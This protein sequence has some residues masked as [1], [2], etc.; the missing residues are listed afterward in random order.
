MKFTIHETF[1]LCPEVR[2]R[3]VNELR[4]LLLCPRLHTVSIRIECFPLKNE[5]EL[6]DILRAVAEVYAR[7]WGKIG[8]RFKLTGGRIGAT[9]EGSRFHLGFRVLYMCHGSSVLQLDEAC[10]KA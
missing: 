10:P 5:E 9:R 8:G 6:H 4:Q 7:L 1:L 2:D 3:L